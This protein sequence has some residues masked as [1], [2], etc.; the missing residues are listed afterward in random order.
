VVMPACSSTAK[1]TGQPCAFTGKYVDF[2]GNYHCGIHIRALYAASLH[3]L[4]RPLS[5][6]AVVIPDT[7]P[8]TPVR[9]RTGD[10][11]DPTPG[12]LFERSMLNVG[13]VENNVANLRMD[14]GYRRCTGT[15]VRGRPCRNFGVRNMNDETFC[16]HHCPIVCPDVDLNV[17]FEDPMRPIVQFGDV[18]VN[19]NEQCPICFVVLKTETIVKTNCGHVF[20][21]SCIDEWLQSRQTCPLCRTVTHIRRRAVHRLEVVEYE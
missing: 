7:P 14:V 17:F 9:T 19:V 12:N 15:T 13:N 18:G 4:R 5:A 2:D 1:R 3:P 11:F 21:Q 8:E 20:H 6:E 16:R 10:V